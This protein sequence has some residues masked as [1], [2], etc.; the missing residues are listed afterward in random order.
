MTLDFLEKTF[1]SYI[2]RN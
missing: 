2:W 1:L